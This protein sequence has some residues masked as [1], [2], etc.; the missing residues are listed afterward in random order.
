MQDKLDDALTPQPVA[1]TPGVNAPVPLPKPSSPQDEPMPSGHWLEDTMAGRGDIYTALFEPEVIRD[2]MKAEKELAGRFEIVDGKQK[3]PRLP[4]Q[5]TRAEFQ[6]LANT[7]SD[8]RLGRGDL[9]IDTK[10][11]KDPEQFKADMMNDIGD[12]LQTKSGRYLIE[13]LS[14]S[15]NID[16]QGNTVHRHTTL[17]PAVD[18]KGNLDPTL[19]R[20][21]AVG[22][23]AFGKN[24]VNDDGTPGVGTD[25]IIQA[26][27]NMDFPQTDE[28]GDWVGNMRSD[29]VLFH[30]LVHAYTDTRGFTKW[31]QVQA[32][33]SFIS[34]V[35]G[36]RLQ[37]PNVVRD[38]NSQNGVGRAEYQAAGLGL[39]ML[40]PITENAYR[41]ERNEVG[42]S[43]KGIAGDLLMP[44]RTSYAHSDDDYKTIGGL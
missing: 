30:E 15:T 22:G 44:Q 19:S 32:D 14:D 20:E 7:Y 40:D 6:K 29:V 2:R 35:P 13:S 24:I 28:N 38:A 11:A 36:L 34:A 12:I 27:P 10:G 8:I 1:P 3:G 26:A 25:A 23:S 43:G 18:E 5:I 31:G 33:E 17:T 21:N 42:K 39:H 9:T 41:R 16:D 37:D 4:N